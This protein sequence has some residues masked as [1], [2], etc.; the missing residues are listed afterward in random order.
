MRTSLPA[1]PGG[2]Q[3]EPRGHGGVLGRALD[4]VRADLAGRGGRSVV[5]AHAWVQGAEGSDSERDI[6]VG[7]TSRVAAALFDGLTYTALGHLHGA[8]VLGE[9][10]RYS[11]SPLAYSFSE[12]GHSKG[13]WLVELDGVGVARV[14][15]VPSPA[16]RRLSA[17]RGTLDRL[18]SDPAHAAAEH[19][20]LSVTLTDPVRPEEAMARL[21]TRFPH[22]LVLDWAPEGITTDDRSYRARL[23]HQDDLA[24]STA[25]L[26]HVRSGGAAGAADAG[27]RALLQEALEAGRLQVVSA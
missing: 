27:E 17:V 19:D 11:G 2:S 24:V 13:C 7:G 23:A 16:A 25:F 12:A 3:V 20:W 22:V 9:G 5:L 1:D 10:L 14:D 21:R 26:E 6:T 4:C 18:L 8:Q 15:Q